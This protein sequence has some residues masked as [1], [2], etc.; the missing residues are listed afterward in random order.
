MV[1]NDDNNYLVKL[2]KDVLF[3]NKPLLKSSLEKIPNNAFVL[4][5]SSK[6]DFIDKD[7]IDVIQEYK[8]HAGLKNIRVEI[9][10]NDNNFRHDSLN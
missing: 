8:K 1:V 6:A 3:I 2:R 7:I 4:I 9:K 10:K 5:D